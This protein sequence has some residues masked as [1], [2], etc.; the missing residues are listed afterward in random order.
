VDLAAGRAWVGAVAPLRTLPDAPIAQVAPPAADPVGTYELWTTDG[1]R[2][3]RGVLTV[4]REGGALRAALRGW[5]EDETVAV[6]D[7]RVEG[8][9]LRADLVFRQPYPL[10]L[11]FDGVVGKGTWGDPTA[12]GGS[13]EATKRS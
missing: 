1:G 7:V 6:R 5:A 10:V 13:A 8:S 12:R 11:D 4:W 3:E 9:R 2:R